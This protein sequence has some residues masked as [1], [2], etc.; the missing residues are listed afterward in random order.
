MCVLC[1]V[2]CV[3]GVCVLCVVCV[4][5]VSVNLC[6]Q[7]DLYHIPRVFFT[8]GTKPT[9]LC[10]EVE[11]ATPPLVVTSDLCG[12]HGSPEIKIG[13]LDTFLPA[14]ASLVSLL[15][16]HA[17][18][19]DHTH[20]TRPLHRGRCEDYATRHLLTPPTAVLEK[21]PSWVH[22]PFQITEWNI[23]KDRIPIPLEFGSDV[24][25]ARLALETT[26]RKIQEILP[27]GWSQV[28]AHRHTFTLAHTHTTHTHTPHTHTH[29]HTT[30]GAVRQTTAVHVLSLLPPLHVS[31]DDT[32]GLCPSLNPLLTHLPASHPR[33]SL[34]R[35]PSHPHTLPPPPHTLTPL[36]QSAPPV[37]SNSG[38][39]GGP[40]ELAPRG[41]GGR[42]GDEMGVP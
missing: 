4:C 28:R 9:V 18:P 35:G 39:H 25:N 30:G 6:L 40:P 3:C 12:L 29:T 10:Q 7:S 5:V 14:L 41:L 8:P 13:H 27:S 23:G 31:R 36:T 26:V 16:Q 15:H 33:P 34:P 19:T 2:C 17:P 22:I 20:Q 11:S 1:A 38:T 32:D 21:L 42:P 24:R 37:G